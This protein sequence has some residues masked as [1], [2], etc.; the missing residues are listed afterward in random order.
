MKGCIPIQAI[1]SFSKLNSEYKKGDVLLTTVS[2][3]PIIISAVSAACSIFCAFISVYSNRM[4]A[5][6]EFFTA[7]EDDKF[8]TA[9]KHIYNSTDQ[10]IDDEDAAFVV[11]F[12]H[13]WGLLV[14][15]HYLPIWVFDTGTGRGACRLYEKV[16]VYIARRREEH[17]DPTYAEYYQWLYIKLQKRK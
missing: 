13:H 3:I 16:A 14:K 12:F 7:V 11:N 2:L 4:N 15:K 17:H 9:K 1:R 10:S 6:N 8:I 5:I